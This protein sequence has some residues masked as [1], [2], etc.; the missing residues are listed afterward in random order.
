MTKNEIDPAVLPPTARATYFH[1]LRVHI[2]IVRA[3]MLDIDCE[4]DPCDWGWQRSKEVL[5]PIMTDLPPAAEFLLN[6]VRCNCKTTS[7]NTC[8]TLL[9]SCR[10]NGLKCVQACGGCRGVACHNT[11]PKRF[12]IDSIRDEA[13]P[14][15]IFDA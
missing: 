7:R 11:E 12:E 5:K 15:G 9:C 8:G 3:V 4:L 10:K 2:E 13:I 6:V 14:E 1:S